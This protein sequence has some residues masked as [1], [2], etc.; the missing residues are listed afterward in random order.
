MPTLMGGKSCM[1][2]V[3]LL[4]HKIK[5]PTEQQ[6][7][8]LAHDTRPLLSITLYHHHFSLLQAQH[9]SMDPVFFM[10]FAMLYMQFSVYYLV[11]NRFSHLKD[12]PVPIFRGERY[13][14]LVPPYTRQEKKH[15]P[16]PGKN[17][18][19]ALHHESDFILINKTTILR[20]KYFK[21]ILCILFCQLTIF[22]HPWVTFQSFFN[23][24]NLV[25]ERLKSSPR[26]SEISLSCTPPGVRLYISFRSCY[27]GHCLACL[28]GI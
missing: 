9:W 18:F 24:A 22:R 5:I 1:V 21:I 11:E 28:Y 16:F 6:E 4:A 3:T 10:G 23:S 27:L 7:W 14:C 15:A 12:K 13:S 19:I 17:L 8:S 20:H 26:V 25:R 2:N